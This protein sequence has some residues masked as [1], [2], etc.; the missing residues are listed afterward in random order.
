MLKDRH[1]LEP[2]RVL[3]RL[4][5][6][7]PGAAFEAAGTLQRRLERALLA[8]EFAAHVGEATELDV[9]AGFRGGR[10]HRRVLDSAQG[11]D[12]LLP[13]RAVVERTQTDGFCLGQQR[14]GAAQA[15]PADGCGLGELAFD[16][17]DLRAHALEL[18][19]LR[20]VVVGDGAQ[21]VGQ[22]VLDRLG[23]EA[24]AR[25]VEKV[26]ALRDFGLRLEAEGEGVADRGGQRVPRLAWRRLVQVV[27]HAYPGR[28]QRAQA[29]AIGGRPQ[30]TGDGDRHLP[31]GLHID[32]L[33]GLAVARG[34]L[35]RHESLSAASLQQ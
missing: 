4:R 5:G 33:A 8:Y 13:G 18:L 12:L 23:H 1:R 20:D 22:S 14:V 10:G 26:L 11:F 9:L 28:Q 34:Q 30:C 7:A 6:V 35:A 31:V 21:E 2:G 27:G 29:V 3:A 24:V 16:L 17:P 32:R 19:L 25:A 15:F